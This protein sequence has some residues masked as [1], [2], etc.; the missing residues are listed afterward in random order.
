VW[1]SAFTLFWQ[2][3][4][5]LFCC[6]A[7]G[8]AWRFF[9]PKEFS[10]LNKVVFS[11]VGGLFLAV[12][13]AQNLVYLGVPVRVSAWL[14]LGAA[15]LQVFW[16]RRQVIAWTPAF[17][18]SSETST[19]VVVIFLTVLFHGL[20]PIRQGLDWY[21]GKGHFDQI[22]YVLL[23]EFLKEEPY[24]TSEQEIGLR[25]WLVRSVGFTDH[26]EQLG[27]SS[28]PVQM[29]NGLKKER[30][31]QSIITAE[32]SVWSGT[33]AKGGYPATVI[34]FLTMLAISLYAFLREIE[35]SQ[36][37]AG[38]GALLGVFLPAITRLSLNGFLSQVSILFVF[39]FFA[40]LLRRQELNARSFTLFFS[41]TLAY[42]IA[43]YSEIAPLGFCT[44]LL[45][46]LLIR[47]DDFR[48]KRLIF[49]CTIL[50]V[51]LVNPYY[52]RNLIGFLG[53]QYFYAAN[54]ALLVNL[55]PDLAS[56]RG[57]SELLFGDMG[58]SLALFFDGVA[59]LVGFLFL[60]GLVAQCRPAKLIVG[61]VLLPGVLLMLYLGTRTPPA[62]YP[63]AKVAL[64][65]LPFLV[66][67]VFVPLDRFTENSPRRRKLAAKLLAATIVAAAAV[68]SARYYLEVLNDGDLLKYVREP[69]FL[70]V[71]RELEE[72]KDKRIF[73]F[74]THPLLTSWLCYHARHNDVY[75][76]GRLISDSPVPQVSSFAK[77]SDL[78]NIDLVATRD[79][80]VDLKS[81]NV[82]C[83]TLVD[84]IRGEDRRDGHIHYWLGAPADLRFL[85][86]RPISAQLNIRLAPGP[87]ATVLPVDYFLA[88]GQGQI[89][90]GEI[91]DNSVKVRQIN[92]PRGFSSLELSVKT[93]ESDLNAVSVFPILAE[94]GGIE[95]SDINL[96]PVK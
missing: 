56:L 62:Y 26:A 85:V 64:S 35:V 66:T 43:A 20:V 34:F 49:M 94:L 38:S 10:L 4:I 16:L 65:F 13:I 19:L 5:L 15:V 72:T 58:G 55:V 63:I 2:L 84:A 74:E 90:H 17:C 21:Y 42:V 57:W 88:D 77:F 54:S 28:G 50:L 3:L 83:L 47:R 48:A 45:G 82:S 69:H 40:I 59:I 51:T 37:W 79:Q 92:F 29:I 93:K 6:S 71:C 61:A 95:L 67:L 32:I 11:L 8:L 1:S 80:I 60:A 14:I 68:G 22:N 73:I 12:L 89:S 25:P 33:D 18:S 53:Q 70:K 44:F 78:E 76:N 9:I 24:G 30:I 87:D 81:S 86:L 91:W 41:F 75:F 52:L 31:G 7:L 46:L 36:F 27:A 23:A 96:N 39:S